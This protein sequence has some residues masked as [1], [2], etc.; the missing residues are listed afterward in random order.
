[1]KGSHH[2]MQVRARHGQQVDVTSSSP[3]GVA[4]EDAMTAEPTITAIMPAYN[5]SAVL[6]QSLP[7][8][9]E[10]QRRGRISEVI[11]VDDGSTDGTPDIA[12]SLGARV[13]ATGRRC[14]P[15]AARN[16]G[17]ANAQGNILWFVDSDVIAASDTAEHIRH[18]L[19]GGSVAVF[20]SYDDSP[21]AKNFLSQYKNLVHHHYHQVGRRDASTFWAGCGAVRKDA[22]L[23]VGGFNASRYP[24]PSIEDIDLGYNLRAAGGQIRLAPEIQGTHL[25]VWT[26]KDLLV[27]EVRDRAIPWGLLLLS[28]A[29]G[30]NDLNIAM[31]E[32]V[33]AL[34]A[35]LLCLAVLTS[36]AGVTSWWLPALFLA[37][38][39]VSNLE[40]FSLFMR[41]NGLLFAIRGLMFHQF[42][43][44]YSTATY[45]GCWIAMR[46]GR[47]QKRSSPVKN[48]QAVDFEPGS[49]GLR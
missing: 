49:D 9:L 27:T 39:F 41:V 14:G 13:I 4:A 5:C 38:A 20:G 1:M 30:G 29:G 26:L 19:V 32:R 10:L 28:G 36:L 16:L 2:K 35:C 47:L 43:Y 34:I 7:P 46:S 6:R 22:F 48:S 23:E 17:A 37:M 8:L 12:A 45:C 21:S 44:L 11:L 24:R 25:K 40:L 15:A 42:Y 3:T 33:R 18:V 31:T